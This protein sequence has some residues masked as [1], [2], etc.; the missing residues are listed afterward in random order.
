MR[1]TDGFLIGLHR[2]PNSNEPDGR[3]SNGTNIA[4]LMRMSLTDGFLIGLQRGPNTNT[5]C[6]RHG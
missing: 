4:V 5:L 3:I 2:G 6:L 1:L